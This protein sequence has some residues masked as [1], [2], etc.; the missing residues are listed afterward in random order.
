MRRTCIISIRGKEHEWA[1]TTELSSDSVRGMRA[2][3]IEV[4]EAYY[5]IPDWAVYAHMGQAWM[6]IVDIFHFRNPFKT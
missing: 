2:D 1:I 5:T 3:G 4:G 6:F